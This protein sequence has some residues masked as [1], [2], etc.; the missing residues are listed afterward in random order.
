[1]DDCLILGGGIVGL[2]LAYELACQGE[3]IRVID[4]G[5]PGGES[6]WAGAG[7]LPPAS[8]RPDASALE[9]L[10]ALANRGHARWF[11]QLREETGIDNG[12]RRSGGLYLVRGA[13]AARQCQAAVAALRSTGVAAEMLS[14]ARLSELEPALE[15]A[16]PAAVYCLSDEC[17]V[18]NPR[19]IKALLAACTARGVTISPG[20]EA[21]DFQV[22]QRRIEGVQ[23]VAGTLRA[24]RYCIA[25][26]AWS[27][28]L[29]G[30]LAWQPAIKPVRGQIVLLALD[31]SPLERVVN[32]GPRY[33]VPRSDGHVLVGSTEEDAGFDKRTTAAGI[34]GLMDFVLSLA[35]SLAAARFERCW[36]GLRPATADGLPYLGRLPD[37]DNGFIAAGH[38]RSGLQLSTAT[39]VVMAELMR[40]QSPQV[41][42]SAF[43]PQRS[44]SCHGG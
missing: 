36:A 3:R 43:S 34:G 4:R 18:R 24:E 26:G 23:T 8:N 28:A 32:D 7:I 13:D 38:F 27:R 17:Q 21:E 15:P 39:A 35:P 19:H 29:A 14:P 41:D 30:R 2:S 22:H 44:L 1:M 42:L 9:Q 5:P 10:T 37:Y 33:L 12:Y 31:R 11:E 40:G 20:V 16:E 6:S 25:S